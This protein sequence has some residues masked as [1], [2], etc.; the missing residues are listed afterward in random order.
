METRPTI[1]VSVPRVYE[2]VYNKVMQETRSGIKR[3]IYEWAIRVGR[4]HRNEIL[5]GRIPSSWEWKVANVLL[6]SKIY[7]GFGGQTR[8]FISGGAPLGIDLATWFA[9]MGIVI[10]QGYGLT[11]TSPVIAINTPEA[12]R[13]GTAGAR[14]Q[15]LPWLLEAS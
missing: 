7:K 13:L 2:K 11:E 6:F 3:S 9:D 4:A 15:R 12:N 10:L 14:P 1:L 5:A 8:A